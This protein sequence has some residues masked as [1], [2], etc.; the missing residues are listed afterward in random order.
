MKGW[1]NMELVILAAGM[2]S[3]FGGL[4][5]IEPIDEYNNFI[6]D[7]SI[8]DAIEAGFDK[9]VFIIKKENYEIFKETIGNRIANKIKVSYVF[10]ELDQ[11]PSNI[12]LPLN[13]IKPWGT[14][15]AVLAAKDEVSDS[16]VIINA[17]DYYGKDA[18][19]VAFNYLKSLKATDVGKYANVA[20]EA[21]KT[22]T[23]NGSVKRGVCKIDEQGNLKEII[24][25]SLE[26]KDGKIIATPLDEA[27][28]SFII[29]NNQLVSMNMFIFTKDIFKHLEERFS[30][31]YQKSND[32]LKFEYLIPE[33]VSDLMNE[34]L[35]SVKV[36]KTT[37]TWLGVTYYQDKELVYKSLK[38]LVDKGFYKKGLWTEN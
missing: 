20:F 32:P 18:Y 13:R 4:K 35:A 3:R 15:H 10:Q 38:V 11:L 26:T 7:Y 5:Q 24:E 1:E 6:V 14:A 16:F 25:S 34:N 37:S 9:V 28:D 27:K 30:Y 21:S 17:D 19:K 12:K 29:A 22:L 31:Y 23:E 33:V 8:Y 2:G 36:L